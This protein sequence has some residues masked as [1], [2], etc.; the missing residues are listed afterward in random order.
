[1]EEG[2]WWVVVEVLERVADL[3]D[4]ATLESVEFDAIIQ[5][6][7]DSILIPEMQCRKKSIL[8]LHLHKLQ[9]KIIS[10]TKCG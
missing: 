8:N 2:S 5:E 1:M 4:T 3:E 9:I 10:I 7:P 6:I